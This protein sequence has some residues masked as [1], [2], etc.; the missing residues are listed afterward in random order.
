MTSCMWFLFYLPTANYQYQDISKYGNS[1]LFMTYSINKIFH[2]F[3]FEINR[4][5]IFMHHL[6]STSIK[7]HKYQM[8]IQLTSKFFYKQW[9]RK[10]RGSRG[11]SISIK[12]K[13]F[14]NNMNHER[15][16]SNFNNR[17]FISEKT[18]LYTEKYYKYQLQL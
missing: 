10:G 12:K 14:K 2:Y 17:S 16:F 6:P 9:H 1:F 5:L 4:F 13:F 18:I 15:L 8:S 7:I 11:S 3:S